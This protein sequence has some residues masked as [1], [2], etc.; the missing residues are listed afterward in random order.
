MLQTDRKS[1][2]APTL[3]EL[4]VMKDI[5]EQGNVPNA[6]SPNGLDGTAFVPGS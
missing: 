1:Y 2:E 3:Q 5:T 4:G 6:D